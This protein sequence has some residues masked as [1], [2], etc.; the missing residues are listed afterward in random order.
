MRLRWPGYALSLVPLL[1]ACTE[2]GSGP[3]RI[4]ATL[5]IVAGDGQ[6]ALPGQQLATSLRVKAVDAGGHAVSGVRVHFSL[7]DTAGTLS[8]LSAETNSQGTAETRWTLPPALGTYQVVA[9]ITGVDSVTFTGSA[10][11]GAP[12]TLSMVGGDSI[13]GTAGVE[14]DSA[15]VVV[16]RDGLGA[17][18][19]G[20][21]VS[22][23]PQPGSGAVSAEVVRT[24]SAGNASTRWILGPAAGY[25][26]L[27]ASTDSA[28]AVPIT[29]IAFPRATTDSLAVGNYHA[30]HLQ[31]T[32]VTR[33]WGGN[34]FGQL[35]NADT[36]TVVPTPSPISGSSGFAA[37]SPGEDFTCGITS[38]SAVCWGAM[39]GFTAQPPMPLDNPT[40]LVRVVGGTGWICALDEAGEV[41]CRGANN[42]GQLG[43]GTTQDRLSFVPVAGGYQFR[44]I[45]AGSGHACGITLAG[46]AYC[47]GGNAEGQLGDGTTIERHVP[48]RVASGVRFGSISAGPSTTC[49]LALDGRAFCW[50]SDISAE[51]ATGTVTRQLTP[52]AVGGALRFHQFEQSG[53]LLCGVTMQNDGYCWGYNSLGNLGDGSFT[54]RSS[55]VP[56]LGG[57]KFAE[58]HPGGYVTCGRD[59]AGAVHCWGNNSFGGLGQGELQW[60]PAPAPVSSGLSFSELAAGG[61]HACGL[62]SAG[63]PH[64]WGSNRGY[65]LGVGPMP[66]FSPLP[67]PSAGGLTLARLSPGEFGG[68]GLTPANAAYC[69][70]INSLGE[71]GN[72]TLGPVTTPAAVG[73]GLTFAAIT[74]PSEYWHTCGL[75][76]SGQA[77]CWGANHFQQ[78]G[79]GPGNTVETS[80]VAVSGG[81]VFSQITVGETYTCG[82]TVPGVAYCWGEGQYLGDGVGATRYQPGPVAGGLSFT[83]LAAAP[84]GRTTCGLTSAGEAWCWGQGIFG[85]LGDGLGTG[86]ALVPVQV[87]GGHTFTQVSGG[88]YH[89]CGVTVAGEVYCWG[90]NATGAVGKPPGTVEATPVK[91]SGL[92]G[93]TQVA[94]GAAFTC[95]LDAAGHASCWGTG[96]YGQLGDGKSGFALTPVMVP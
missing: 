44:T 66:P 60:R 65:Q 80:P 64:C 68:C 33:C 90:N 67:L 26:R 23:T 88:A 8:A 21:P 50:G 57:I 32:G 73:G 52:A 13:L 87:V 37:L 61:S 2:D 78:R 17:P 29:G 7:P 20:V 27:V 22:F 81:M 5:E 62:T 63:A 48:T 76:P 83:R 69:W 94:A 58:I 45:E 54:D 38:G 56:V 47:W 77:Y 92:S 41:L 74:G 6:A 9:V 55:P 75:T 84:G 31:T 85:E 35:G 46:Q 42:L 18:L 51:I 14:L 25:H 1:L 19:P 59:L 71:M 43:D 82:L 95:A 93:I 96:E 49:A 24:D 28:V 36:S 3:R 72:G 39:A 12:V 30:C 53:G 11:V 16:L 10:T 40:R 86:D 91:V 15:V 4:P 34:Y 89:L 79:D 70:G